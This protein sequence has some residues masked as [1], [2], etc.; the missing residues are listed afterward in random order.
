M[1]AIQQR[2]T[3]DLKVMCERLEKSINSA[4]QA[5]KGGDAEALEIA[6]SS[7]KDELRNR[8]KQL[9]AIEEQ[10]PKKRVLHPSSLKSQM[11]NAPPTIKMKKENIVIVK[12]EVER[13]VKNVPFDNN[14]MKRYRH[15]VTIL[16]VQLK[17]WM[18]I[19]KDNKEAYKAKH[20][21]L[22]T[23]NIK[24]IV[25]HINRRAKNDTWKRL[26]LTEVSYS[27]GYKKMRF[28]FNIDKVLKDFELN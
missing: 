9:V 2:T 1:T 28:S 6:L 11:M 21:K 18:M 23:D 8:S 16:Q 13:V 19:K 15:L 12:E 20:Q 5:G 10:E 3:E 4:Y 7:I 27:S 14:D 22:A 25:E 17:A 26:L 24:A